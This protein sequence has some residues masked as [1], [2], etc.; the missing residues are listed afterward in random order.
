MPCIQMG[1]TE[2]QDS[3]KI[4]FIGFG[5]EKIMGNSVSIVFGNTGK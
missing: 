4:V 1:K 5:N 2:K 3:K